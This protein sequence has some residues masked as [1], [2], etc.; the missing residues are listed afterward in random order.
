MNTFNTNKTIGFVRLS[1]IE[2]TKLSNNYQVRLLDSYGVDEIF[3][4]NTVCLNFKQSVSSKLEELGLMDKLITNSRLVISC[5]SRLIGK[6]KHLFDFLS[7]CKVARIKLIIL[8][9]GVNCDKDE[10]VFASRYTY[11]ESMKMRKEEYGIAREELRRN[12][13]KDIQNN[14]RK[15]LRLITCWQIATTLQ[16]PGISKT[17]ASQALNIRREWIYQNKLHIKSVQ[18]R[19]LRLTTEEL[20]KDDPLLKRQILQ[21]LGY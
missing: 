4:D 3:T 14:G 9:Q 5:A 7:Y 15:G 18:D 17:A 21:E 2:D 6:D 19:Y 16:Q 13:L 12:S 1:N 10:E 8:E 20:R 11:L